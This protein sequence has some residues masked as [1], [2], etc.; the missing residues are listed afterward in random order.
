MPAPLTREL[1]P[2]HQRATGSITCDQPRNAAQAFRSRPGNPGSRGHLSARRQ[3]LGGPSPHHSNA[4]H[5]EGFV[6]P[7]PA[8]RIAR[9]HADLC[10]SI[11]TSRTEASCDARRGQHRKPWALTIWVR[12]VPSDASVR[13]QTNQRGGQA[14][15]GYR[16]RRPARAA[17]SPRPCAP[18][19][20]ARPTR[21]RLRH[22]GIFGNRT[23]YPRRPLESGQ[24]RWQRSWPFPRAKARACGRPDDAD[25]RR[26]PTEP[27]VVINRARTKYLPFGSLSSGFRKN[28][29]RRR[30]R[31]GRP[32]A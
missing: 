7:W 16:V 2:I 5:S 22:R 25:A 10:D 4:H 11:V 3:P 9:R 30:G 29:G 18:D 20:H 26:R 19:R 28:G 12:A 1:G 21:P 15:L 23:G 31:R 24:S 27:E 17:Q 14:F 8:R 32:S 6:S 13:R